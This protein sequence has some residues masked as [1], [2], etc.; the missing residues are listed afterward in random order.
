M[1]FNI[2]LSFGSGGRKLGVEHRSSGAAGEQ[3]ASA[4]VDRTLVGHHASDR[5]NTVAWDLYSVCQ[6]RGL[7]VV[8]APMILVL[9]L[10]VQGAMRKCLVRGWESSLFY[11]A[12]SSSSY[13]G[14]SYCCS[15]FLPFEP[16]SEKVARPV[17]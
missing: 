12:D 15:T 13:L 17:A 10:C 3:I 11:L 8:T 16:R 1:L 6:I 7:G 5:P 2:L 14:R 4:I 9:G